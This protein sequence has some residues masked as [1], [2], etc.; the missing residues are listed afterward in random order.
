MQID[1]KFVMRISRELKRKLDS[2]NPK[3]QQHEVRLLILTLIRELMQI[4]LKVKSVTSIKEDSQVPGGVK[5]VL[6]RRKSRDRGALGEASKDSFKVKESNDSHSRLPSDPNNTDH[7]MSTGP[8]RSSKSKTGQDGSTVFTDHMDAYDFLQKKK[9]GK[10]N[11]GTKIINSKQM[12]TILKKFQS[13]KKKKKHDNGAEYLFC[14]QNEP[15]IC[16]VIRRLLVGGDEDQT[17]LNGDNIHQF[18]LLGLQMLNII[19]QN[20]YK[21]QIQERQDEYLSLTKSK[22]TDEA[23][24]VQL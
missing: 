24:P 7:R 15:D 11:V 13:D 3:H 22:L 5:G 4:P 2:K 20:A 12:Q 6:A 19:I 18:T 16:E 8:R 9:R 23:L 17:P 21:S 1:T 10:K 14:T